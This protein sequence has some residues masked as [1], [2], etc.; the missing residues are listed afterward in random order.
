MSI[1]RVIELTANSEESFEDALRQGVARATQTLRN[2]RSAWVK[3]QEVQVEGGEI[4]G[5]KVNMLVT[6]VLDDAAE[7]DDMKQRGS[8][9]GG[10]RGRRSGG[11]GRRG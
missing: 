9:T 7:L 5:Y 8:G 11:R 3:D 6:F 1:A 4:T 10:G 2:V